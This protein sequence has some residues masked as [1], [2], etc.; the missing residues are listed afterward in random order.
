MNKYFMN[1]SSHEGSAFLC[2]CDAFLTIALN[3]VWFI[4]LSKNH[5]SHHS[6]SLISNGTSISA[7]FIFFSM[8]SFSLYHFRRIL[9]LASISSFITK[10]YKTIIRSANNHIEIWYWAKVW[11]VLSF[12]LTVSIKITIR[13]R[14]EVNYIRWNHSQK[15]VTLKSHLVCT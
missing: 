3:Y 1:I 5:F 6:V 12:E 9:L 4:K 2:W 11:I 10:K 7:L 8:F 14:T 15:V 13:T